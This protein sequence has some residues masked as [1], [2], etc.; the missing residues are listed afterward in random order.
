M[1]GV[2][3]FSGS[4]LPRVSREIWREVWRIFPSAMLFSTVWVM[5]Q[6]MSQIFTQKNGVKTE[7]FTQISSWWELALKKPH[8]KNPHQ[9]NPHQKNPHLKLRI[10]RFYHVLVL[11]PWVLSSTQKTT[12]EAIP[13]AWHAEVSLKRWLAALPNLPCCQHIQKKHFSQSFALGSQQSQ[14]PFAV[15]QA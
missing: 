6:K 5:N 1:C 8:Q 11:H 4:S 12:L 7:N 15:S 9:K 14:C 10:L 3:L 2:N 13:M